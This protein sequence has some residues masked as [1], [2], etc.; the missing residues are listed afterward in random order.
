MTS[1]ILRFLHVIKVVF[2]Y[3]GVRGIHRML[4][5]RSE[6]RSNQ[7]LTEVLEESRQA[8]HPEPRPFLQQ[9]ICCVTEEQYIPR[10]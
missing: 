4:Q 8:T 1:E 2:L 9:Y 3:N 6:A 5:W 10:V 7:Q